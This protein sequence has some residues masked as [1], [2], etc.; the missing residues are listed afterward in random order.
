MPPGLLHKSPQTGC[1]SSGSLV[2]LPAD[3]LQPHQ[4]STGAQ[5]ASESSH[6]REQLGNAVIR[7]LC[8]CC[9]SHSRSVPQI[10]FKPSG[11]FRRF[12]GFVAGR[13]TGAAADCHT[14][15]TPWCYCG[16][17]WHTIRS[18]LPM[19]LYE[20]DNLWDWG[21]KLP[22][23]FFKCSCCITFFTCMHL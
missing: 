12:R 14:T 16:F 7:D 9:L 21:L 6:R 4:T 8:S 1:C 15:S 10:H 20:T 22:V 19:R 13:T 5:P 18:K 11:L 3:S 17:Q 23:I 2:R